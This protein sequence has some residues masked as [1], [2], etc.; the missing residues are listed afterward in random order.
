[1]GIRASRPH[2]ATIRQSNLV[3][4]RIM[5]SILKKEQPNMKGWSTE[6][7]SDEYKKL[8]KICKDKGLMK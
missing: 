4:I 6:K 5:S 7:I 2:N 8:H 1:M 3:H